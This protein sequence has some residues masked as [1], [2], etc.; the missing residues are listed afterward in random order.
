MNLADVLEQ[1]AAEARP[2]AARGSVA[3]YIPE[4]GRVDPSRFGIAFASLEGEVL[5]CGDFETMFS[6]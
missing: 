5:G 3:T 2:A 4:L 6:I 1:V